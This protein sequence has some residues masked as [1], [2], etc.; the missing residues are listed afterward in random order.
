MKEEHKGGVSGRERLALTVTA[1]VPGVLGTL[2]VLA[3]SA[4]TLAWL[5]PVIALPVGLLLCRAWE[6]LGEKGLPL[7]L[8]GA[9]GRG[10]GKC[11]EALYLLWA[12]FLT[13]ERADGY[14]RR[15]MTTTEG[16]S[17]RWLYL[18]VGLALCL[19]LSRGGGAV[20]ARTGKL[21]FLAVTVV[22]ALSLLLAL[23]GA[24]WRNLWPPRTEDLPGLPMAAVTA[25]SLSGY[26]VFAL[27]LPGREEEGRPGVWTVGSCAV[28]SALIL[29]VVGAFGPAL[30][31][32][33]KEP[34]LLL[35]QGVE[36]PG[37]F[38]RGEAVLTAALALADWALLALLTWGCGRLWS[39][40]TGFVRGGGVL[41]AGAFLAAGLLPRWPE[42]QRGMT[43]MVVW[44]NLIFGVGL[45]ALGFL[46]KKG[47]RGRKERGKI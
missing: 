11:L 9:F 15:L 1:L 17:V 43:E 41:T 46:L 23:P 36:V 31:A 47:E 35:L 37:A 27:C 38:R 44:G 33:M 45:P 40:L 7:G 19:W 42:L 18:G 24:D 30:A 12:L 34:F 4:G 13:V 32:R 25:L 20:L 29:A 6:D 8:E 10:P 22:L 2:A 39:S 14:A 5:A 26:G 3:G 16:E 28:F 21:F